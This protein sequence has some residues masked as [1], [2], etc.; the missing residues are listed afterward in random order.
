M[1][2]CYRELSL[3]SYYVAGQ[4]NLLKPSGLFTY[5]QGLTS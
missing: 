4:F 2:E 3:K 1:S 5:H